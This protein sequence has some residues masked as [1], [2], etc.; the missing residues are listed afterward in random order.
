MNDIHKHQISRQNGILKKTNGIRERT[1]GAQRLFVCFFVSVLT[2]LLANWFF[3]FSETWGRIIKTGMPLP[4][5][6][7]LALIYSNKQ[8]NAKAIQQKLDKLE[9]EIKGTPNN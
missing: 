7:G 3:H 8:R 9:Q 4:A 5:L 2:L 1:G 6:F